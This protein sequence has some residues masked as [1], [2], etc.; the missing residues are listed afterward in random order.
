MRRFF[1]GTLAH[2]A[3]N[4]GL[5]HDEEKCDC[6]TVSRRGNETMAETAQHAR[7]TVGELRHPVPAGFSDHG[8][9]ASD[10][11]WDDHLYA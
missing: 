9:G 3:L 7:P 6:K 4:E 5:L 8:A 2:G 1:A 10:H 11:S